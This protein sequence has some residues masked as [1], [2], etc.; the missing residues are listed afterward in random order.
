MP[1]APARFVALDV[2]KAYVV[3]GAVEAT[4]TV[5][6]SPR[7]IALVQFSDWAG[8]HLVP[9]DQVVLETTINAWA[10]YDQLV[11]LVSRVVVAN[12]S[13]VKLIAA[14]VVKTDKRDTLALAK[15]LA[16]NLIPEVWV[17]PPEV[18]ELRA[19]VAQRQ[20][21]L[22]QRTMAKN[23][24]QSLLPQH[25]LTAPTTEP[26]VPQHHA[27]W[28]TL[29]QTRPPSE[30]LRVQQDRAL[31][32]YLTTVLATVEAELA[33]VSQQEPWKAQ[34]PFLIQL[35]GISLIGAM[36][37][38]A[39]IDDI[40]RFASAKHMVGYAGLGTRVHASGQVHRSGTI[41]RT[42]RSDLRTILVEAAW[43]VIRTSVWWRARYEH[44]TTRMPA[45]KAIVAIARKLLVVIWHVLTE[46]AADRQ[47][48][49]V[50]VA[51][52]LFRWGAAHHLA[53]QS[54]HSRGGF[55]RK[56]L[57]QLGVGHDLT[58][59]AINGSTYVLKAP[60]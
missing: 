40:T 52:R 44:P 12:P 57:D 31:V 24:L 60:G 34:V 21:L 43:T 22:K 28:E 26:F 23:R 27:W 32:D 58:H 39:A 16:A 18:R 30:R 9:T 54:G 6:L 2:H 19:L 41:T 38:L 47:A 1:D 59:L 10:F 25:N 4:Q 3:I 15:L 46:R 48:D 49:P 50:A 56:A 29:E 14:S 35:P 33:R 45:A 55:V 13:Q 11:P 7:R 20:R 37:V 42:G 53:T 17:P 51:R 8:H 5:V 36:T